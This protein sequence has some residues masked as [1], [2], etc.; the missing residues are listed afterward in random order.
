MEWCWNQLHACQNKALKYSLLSGW[1]K[2]IF[3]VKVL[4]C[5]FKKKPQHEVWVLHYVYVTSS[6]VSLLAGCKAGIRLPPDSCRLRV[7]PLSV[8]SSAC[9]H[10]DWIPDKVWF[11]TVIG[12]LSACKRTQC[13]RNKPC[14]SISEIW[15]VKIS[16][17][18]YNQVFVEWSNKSVPK[19]CAVNFHSKLRTFYLSPVKL[20][21]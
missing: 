20:P 15:N 7:F 18:L 11:S 9:K 4:W 6:S 8:Y 5:F 19:S 10:V 3:S 2:F 13:A 14:S 17:S 16:A 1:C 21:F 12:L